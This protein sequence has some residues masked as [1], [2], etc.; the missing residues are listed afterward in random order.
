MFESSHFKIKGY[1][2]Q[3]A[4]FPLGSLQEFSKKSTTPSVFELLKNS[5]NVLSTDKQQF[6]LLIGK[7]YEWRILPDNY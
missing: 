2:A 1:L 6:F 4:A 7:T 3:P 5:D